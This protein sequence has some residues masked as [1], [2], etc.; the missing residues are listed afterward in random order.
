[1]NFVLMLVCQYVKIRE[2][3]RLTGL[4]YRQLYK[5]TLLPIIKVTLPAVILSYCAFNL[6]NNDTFVSLCI[7]VFVMLIVIAGCIFLIGLN[8]SEKELVM[9]YIKKNYKNDFF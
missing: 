9:S 6:I 8:K 3:H 5:R 1:M 2:A 4:Q 7:N